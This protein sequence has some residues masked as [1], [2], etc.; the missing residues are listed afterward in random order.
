MLKAH[1]TLEYWHEGDATRH[2]ALVAEVRDIEGE[3]VT[4]HVTY[5]CGGRKLDACDTRKILSPLNGHEGCAVR[6]L[7]AEGILG[8]AEGVE[9]ALSA[10]VLDGVPV[11]A[12][13]NTSL[14]AKFQPPPCV[15]LLR[16]Y[17]DRD[18]PGLEAAAR[19]IER[20]QGVVRCELRVPSG[21]HKDF[22]DQLMSR[23][24]GGGMT[25]E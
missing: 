16:V 23:N 15:T 2:A 4:V 21:G 10:A 17:A 3:L 25:R 24:R 13:L 20:L 5:L 6:L 11:W 22:N 12:A 7:P 8:V 1:P 18:A 9:T 19:L 14:M